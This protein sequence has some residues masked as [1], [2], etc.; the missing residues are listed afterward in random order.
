MMNSATR[1]TGWRRSMWMVALAGAIGATGVAWSGGWA[2]VSA[3]ARTP[4][5]RPQTAS[6]PTP[7]AADAALAAFKTYYE[8]GVKDNAVVGSSIMVVRGGETLFRDFVGA[9]R[10]EPRR[11]VDADTIYHW[12]SITKTFTAI[13]IMQLRDRGRLTLD[14]PVVEHVPEFR[15]VHDPFGDIGEVT[16][17][18]MMTHSSGL[19]SAT[20]PWGGDKPW[21]PHEPT[22]WSQVVAMFPYTQI[23]FKPGSRYSYS[24]PGI[25]FLGQIIERLTGDDYEVYV[26][27]NI[28]R[29]LGMLQSYFDATPYH[30]LANRSASYRMSK[31]G[32]KPARFDID[33][34]IT[35]SN[36][37]LNAPL[38]D[39]VRYL[40]FLLGSAD[41]ARQSV[42]DGVLRRSSLLEMF[43]PRLDAGST[44]S[45]R[46]SMGLSFFVEDREGLHTVGHSGSQNAFISHFYIVPALNLGYVV[47]FNT[48]WEMEKAGTPETV[49][50]FDAAIRTRLLKEVFPAL[51]RDR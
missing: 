1:R 31:A 48:E 15:A 13:A 19:R 8:Q 41:P 46:V 37:G 39:M 40:H 4:H 25:I 35:V 50:Q 2:W 49:R 10:L 29:P 38:T 43:E 5:P 14:D 33:T 42:H 18:H 9:A 27:K 3:Q 34:G 30:L 11:A 28:L 26:D 22:A 24:N 21:H 7:P 17:R 16:I 45:D 44:G 51:A 23:E 20:W 12:A 32:P 6:T 36:G 47:A